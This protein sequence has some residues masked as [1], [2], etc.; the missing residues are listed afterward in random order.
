MIGCT[1]NALYCEIY[2]GASQS[3]L[4]YFAFFYT[5]VIIYAFSRED[6]R[7]PAI[8]TARSTNVVS[9][10]PGYR[11]VGQQQRDAVDISWPEIGMS[12]ESI[13]SL[14]RDM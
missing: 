1:R 10:I 13:N 4:S 6:R 11:D 8:R 7:S 14:S 3:P 12:R 5:A 9:R 2:A